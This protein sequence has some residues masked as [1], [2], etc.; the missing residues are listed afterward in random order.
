MTTTQR[1]FNVHLQKQA[2]GNFWQGAPE[3]IVMLANISN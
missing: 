3:Y 2:I 1:I